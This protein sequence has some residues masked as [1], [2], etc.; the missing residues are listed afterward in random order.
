MSS[1][2]V[3]GK[4]F[5]TAMSFGSV[6][7]TTCAA[8]SKAELA[9][10]LAKLTPHEM[11]LALAKYGC[12]EIAKL[13]LLRNVQAYTTSLALKEC[14]KPRT[15]ELLAT[16]ASL[17][18]N[19]VL[20]GNVCDKCHGTGLIGI[21]RVCKCCDGTGHFRVSGRK[22]ADMI[23]VCEKQWRTLWKYRYNAVFEYVQ[24]M[25]STVLTQIHFADFEKIEREFY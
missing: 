4:M 11:N 12:D 17:A 14:W 3:I 22:M 16:M 19:E 8:L 18:V 2:E 21:I 24:Q 20:S 7:G 9:G 1:A 10:M 5:P 23:G 25:E 13:R 15:V 6:R